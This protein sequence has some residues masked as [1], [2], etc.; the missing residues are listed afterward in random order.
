MKR[1]VS[2]PTDEPSCTPET[3]YTK[4]NSVAHRMGTAPRTTS[5]APDSVVNESRTAS[6]VRLGLRVATP[7]LPSVPGM[8][9]SACGKCWLENSPD[10]AGRTVN[11]QQTS[12]SAA[13]FART[14]EGQPQSAIGQAYASGTQVD[15]EN[16]PIHWASRQRRIWLCLETLSTDPAHMTFPQQ[17]AF[18]RPKVVE[19]LGHDVHCRNSTPSGL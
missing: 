10:A 15:C 8:S 16:N 12:F 9:R 3:F 6:E 19:L 5:V 1:R 18:F 14:V 13:L 7:R 2:P 11:A 4:P 17:S